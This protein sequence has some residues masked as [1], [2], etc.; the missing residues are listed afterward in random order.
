MKIIATI[1]AVALCVASFAAAQDCPAIGSGGDTTLNKL[2]NR[3]QMPGSYIRMPVRAFLT[4]TPTI[5]DRHKHMDKFSA[6]DRAK[7]D[8][9]NRLSVAL[10]G[11]LIDAKQSG[12][13]ACNCQSKS[14]HD[15]HVWIAPEPPLAGDKAAAKAMR[16]NSVV[17]EPTPYWQE[18]HG[19]TWRLRFFTRLAHDRARVRVSGWVMYDPEHPDQIGK[20]RATLWEIHPVTK[21]EVWSGGDWR[22]L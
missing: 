14:R 16:A 8:S 12:P 21:V 3:T 15:Y 7:I 1:F 2:K 22:E 17:V 18:Q 6:E 11:F 9:V 10:E 5:D 4:S 13:E 20:T 19:D